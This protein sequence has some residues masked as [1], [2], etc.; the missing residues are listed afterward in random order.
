M[1]RKISIAIVATAASLLLAGGM[2]NAESVFPS[3]GEASTALPALE[4]YADRYAR[5]AAPVGATGAAE[6]SCFPSESS[7]CGPEPVGLGNIPEAVG[8]T[9]AE[10]A[11]GEVLR[12]IPSE[13][14]TDD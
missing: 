10:A 1:L 7:E 4:T 2:A 11:G 9:E 13:W 3:D 14:V 5:E 12:E 8:G 6:E